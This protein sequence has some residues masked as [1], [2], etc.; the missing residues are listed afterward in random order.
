[1]KY[2]VEIPNAYAVIAKDILN[3]LH[4]ST[5]GNTVCVKTRDLEVR[6]CTI[7]DEAL[8]DR[9]R[10]QYADDSDDDIIIDDQP[11]TGPDGDAGIWVA[12]WVFVHNDE[13]NNFYR[14]TDCTV[15]PGIE[16]DDVWSC[17][18]NDRCPACNAEI[19]PYKS[20]EV[21]A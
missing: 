12:A 15:K 17:Q 6:E 9:A 5:G 4:G 14:H 10:A 20:E 2:I 7:A 21:P 3:I 18:C 1:M 19:E 8:R 16:W 13:W 11:E